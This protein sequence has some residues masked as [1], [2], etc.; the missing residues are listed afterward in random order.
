MLFAEPPLVWHHGWLLTHKSDLANFLHN[1]ILNLLIFQKGN[2]ADDHGRDLLGH[3]E[4]D[5]WGSW[6]KEVTSR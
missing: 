5:S 2:R 1:Q 6:N 3:L 4:N